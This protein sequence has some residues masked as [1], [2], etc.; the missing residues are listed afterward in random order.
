MKH[1]KRIGLGILVSAALILPIWGDIYLISHLPNYWNITV[2]L[3]PLVL[4]ACYCWGSLLE[5]YLKR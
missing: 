2:A 1:L 3:L 5:I 4:G